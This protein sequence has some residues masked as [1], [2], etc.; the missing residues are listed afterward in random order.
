VRSTLFYIPAELA[1]VPVFGVGWLLLAW[2]LISLA[3]VAYVARQQGWNRDTLSYFP[4]LAIFCLVIVFV[5]PNLVVVGPDGKPLGIP[6]RGF[7]VMMMLATISAVGLAAYRAWQVGI[8]PE[9]IYSLAFCMF[10]AGIVGAR[11]FY[12]VQKLLEGRLTIPVTASGAIDIPAT[13]V[14]L[15]SVTQGGL[16]VYG[17]VIAGVPA[18]IWYLRRRSLPILP[19]ADIIAPSMAL[20]QAIGRIGCLLNGCCYGGVCLTASYAMTFPPGSGPYDDQIMHSG[21]QSGVWLVQEKEAE[22]VR[23]GYVAPR[24]NAEQAGV[25]VGVTVK[26]INGAPVNSLSDGRKLLS[27][28]SSKYEIETADGAVVRWTMSRPPARSV[29]VHPTQIY[30]AIDAGL[31]ALLLWLYFPFRRRDGEVFAVLITLHP[32]SRFILEA[33]RDDEVG[34]FGTGLTISQ[35]LSLAILAL[36]CVLWWYVERQPR[37]ATATND[38]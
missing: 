4:F 29:P 14:M 10:I 38:E 6:I 24:S 20:G 26:R 5:L 28:T 19:M 27:A 21:W 16:V 22:P 2:I 18:G 11:A 7:G 25:K 35:L 31:L 36:A 37:L 33:I 3:I 8:D 9:V 15:A 32:I 34:Q 1:G 30:A 17:S 13:L 12:I 23:V